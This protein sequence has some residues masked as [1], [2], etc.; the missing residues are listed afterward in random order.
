MAKSYDVKAVLSLDNKGLTAGVDAAKS[1]LEGLSSAF[2]N[3]GSTLSSVG[4]KISSVGAGLS[5]KVTA[6]FAALGIAAGKTA[7]SFLSLKENAHVALETM[8]GDAQKATAYM[9]ELLAF[10]KRTP[11]AF[12][13]ILTAGKNLVAFGMET[14]KTIPLMTAL[15]DAI[16]A[17][18]GKASDLNDLTDIMG[19]IQAQ[20]KITMEEV[21]QLASRGIPALQMF[22]NI[23]GKS[24]DEI[25]ESISKG[26]LDSAQ[27]FDMLIQGIENGTEGMAGSTAK[28]GGMM[29]KL[30]G[31]WTGAI[32]SMKSAWRNASVE[33]VEKS[34]PALK[35]AI[36]TITETIKLLPKVF[37]NVAD[38]FAAIFGK[39]VD[40]IASVVEGISKMEPGQ[41][42]AIG[43]FIAI[44]AV[45]GPV[46][47]VLGKLIGVLGTVSSAIGA[48]TASPVI[49]AVAGIVAA[50]AGIGIAVAGTINESKQHFSELGASAENAG[51]SIQRSF[52]QNIES[53]KKIFAGIW[54][55]IEPAI[56]NI[57]SA[58]KSI[59][60][61]VMPALADLQEKASTAFKHIADALQPVFD[62][63]KR[64]AE[65]MKPLADVFSE[66]L[67]ERLAEGFERL[68]IVIEAVGKAITW[69]CDE[70]SKNMQNWATVIE[71]V[72]G[73]L[74]KLLGIEKE[75]GN[76]IDQMT[77]AYDVFYTTAGNVN[78]AVGG[79]AEGLKKSNDAI[80]KSAKKYKAAGDE[81]TK[82][83]EAS[84]V[85]LTKI[86]LGLDVE[87]STEEF[88]N[89]ISDMASKS[90]DALK[91]L[92]DETVSALVKSGE[93]I[94]KSDDKYFQESISKVSDYFDKKQETVT[95]ASNRINEITAE[96][97]AAG[98]KV[99]L[100][101]DQEISTLRGVI[102]NN[103]VSELSD[104]E[105]RL[106]GVKTALSTENINNIISTN[107]ESLKLVKKNVADVTE[108][109][110][111]EYAN[112]MAAYDLLA[113]AEPGRIEEINA[114]KETARR[115]F[116]EE[117]AKIQQEEVDATLRSYNVAKTGREGVEKDLTRT[118]E[119]E[120]KKRLTDTEANEL[121][122]LQGSKKSNEAKRKAFQENEDDILKDLVMYDDEQIRTAEQ[123]TGIKTDIVSEGYE[124][125][126]TAAE[127]SK[128]DQVGFWDEIKTAGT[129]A[130]KALVEWWEGF[131]PWISGIWEDVKAIVAEKIEEAKVAVHDKIEEIKE[132]FSEIIGKVSEIWENVKTTVTEKIEEAKTV[133]HDKIEEIKAYFA[134]IWSTVS[135]VFN[136]IYTTVNDKI[137]S[138][139]TAVSDAVEGIKSYFSGIGKTVETVFT[140]VKDTVE[141]IL[142][143][144]KLPSLKFPDIKLPSFF[145]GGKAEE[146]AIGGYIPSRRASWVNEKGPELQILQGGTTVIPHDL[147]KRMVDNYSRSKSGQTGD[148]GVLSANISMT[149]T[150]VSPNGQVLGQMIMPTVRAELEREKRGV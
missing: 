50:V 66:W 100:E 74:G 125:I 117:L 127:T 89:N 119:L 61:H 82:L 148:T 71:I 68:G 33:M 48:I 16:A 64:M 35:K 90:I 81:I 133:V 62:A 136:D 34:M 140:N 77:D 80:N 104:A 118:A 55:A 42:Q 69:L 9:D 12:P 88:K 17:T 86:K 36:E 111:L 110:S 83:S 52:Q 114:L 116:T 123:N 41:Q 2:K 5:L 76:A 45:V 67:G 94:G 130:G 147:S 65:A 11:F 18:G 8:L 95:R 107:K 29:Q 63:F 105:K 146:H 32:D 73:G 120:G 137:I 44:A 99:S 3:I 39:I 70:A 24:V 113:E 126:T 43:N 124:N 21:N 23:T 40:A 149:G 37:E 60:T 31:T 87:K 78:I 115:K 131:Y 139:K 96:I 75:S 19:K 53:I 103:T 129:N 101:Q 97:Q 150:L 6:P 20:G 59:M 38:G 109:K 28:M 85:S 58:F 143:N 30:K 112:T 92:K 93:A 102:A 106:T 49:L 22:A 26:T 142:S 145:G 132:K 54:K 57:K 141:R 10:A 56:E 121:K 144:I 98:G 72:A 7:I 135:S 51:Q 91:N 47:I 14:K 128:D 46:L 15:G 138:A 84:A 13:D 25:R 1:K 27:A 108:Q 134:P 79:V 122:K 4:D